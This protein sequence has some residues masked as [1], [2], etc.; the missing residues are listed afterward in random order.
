MEQKGDGYHQKVRE[1]FL[2]LADRQENFVVV[3]ATSDIE[4]VHKDV[5]E[6][7]AQADF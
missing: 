7:I 1:G 5:V 3:D 2:K 4:T 6:I